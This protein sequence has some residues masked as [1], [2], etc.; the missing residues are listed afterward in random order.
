[1]SSFD[2]L[3]GAAIPVVGPFL[4]ENGLVVE[5][6]GVAQAAVHLGRRMG[7]VAAATIA[8]VVVGEDLAGKVRQNPR[9]ASGP[10]GRTSVRIRAGKN[11]LQ[12]SA[13]WCSRR[14]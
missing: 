13:G 5:I 12:A 7:W 14:L 10:S 4:Q 8:A 1:M 11:E 6:V 9:T 2:L 3:V